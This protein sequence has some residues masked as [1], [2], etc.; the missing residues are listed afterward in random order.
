MT[1]KRIDSADNKKIKRVAALKKRKYREETGLFTAEGVRL[2]E[3]AANSDFAIEQAFLT[4]ERAADARVVALTEK[5]AARGGCEMFIVP[6]RLYEKMSNTA[7][8]QGMM[9]VMRQKKYAL[10]FEKEGK[11]A[12]FYVALENVADP[13]NVGTTIRTADA[14]GASGV[15]LLGSCADLY[16]DKTV[17]AAMGS[18]FNIPAVADLSIKEAFDFFAKNKIKTYAAALDEKAAPL[19]AADM[20]KPVV[21]DRIRIVPETFGNSV[22]G[23]PKNGQGTHKEDKVVDKSFNADKLRE[24][25]GERTLT[26]DTLGFAKVADINQMM[27]RGELHKLQPYFTEKFFLT[28]FEKLGGQIYKRNNGHYEIQHVPSVIREI[29]LASLWRKVISGFVSI[30]IVAIFRAL[31]RLN[32]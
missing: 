8:P 30:R 2:A 12:P 23:T 21:G 26:D 20:T 22:I 3:A 24:L 5:L 11:D 14:L 32:F 4:A 29:F 27:E 10:P 9:L 7:S 17:R 28:A 1:Y 16:S 15:L 31:S 19:F 6:R 13:G 25:L 18:L